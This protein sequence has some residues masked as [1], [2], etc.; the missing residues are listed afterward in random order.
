MHG[1]V[2]PGESIDADEV[3]DAAADRFVSRLHGDGD[4]HATGAQHGHAA[5][6]SVASRPAGDTA[7]DLKDARIFWL[8]FRQALIDGDSARLIAWTTFPLTVRGDLDDDP[9]RTIGRSQFPALVRSILKE[10]AGDGEHATVR[11]QVVAT[12]SL[13]SRSFGGS[14]GKDFFGVGPMNFQR[15]GGRWRL[16]VAYESPE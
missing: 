6:A 14:D 7:A 11:E 13:N 5:P 1:P 15:V 10:F 2:D 4:G 8:A 3:S 12:T 9:V 16:T